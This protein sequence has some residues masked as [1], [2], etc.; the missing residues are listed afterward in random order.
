[1]K[2]FGK[3]VEGLPLL[4]DE[5]YFVQTTVQPDRVED[6]PH[7]TV[8]FEPRQ[9]SA[10]RCVQSKSMTAI[11]PRAGSTSPSLSNVSSVWAASDLSSLDLAL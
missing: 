3:H 4:L 8:L 6:L 1:M 10:A 2:P 11:S 9:T 7:L 5:V